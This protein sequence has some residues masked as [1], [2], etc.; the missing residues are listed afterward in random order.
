MYLVGVLHNGLKS[1]KKVKFREDVAAA[2]LGAFLFPLYSEL[3]V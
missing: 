1:E 2:F 3:D